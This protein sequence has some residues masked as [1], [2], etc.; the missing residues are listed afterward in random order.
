MFQFTYTLLQD[1]EG[2]IDLAALPF[3]GDNAED[4]PDVFHGFEVISPIPEHV[5]DPH[6]APTL[7]FAQAGADVRTRYGERGRD[8]FRMQWLLGEEEQG[9][10]L[11]NGPVNTPTGAHLAPVQDEFLFNRRERHIQ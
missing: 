6:D 5:D 8:F 9:M 2:G 10:H 11:G 7:Q 4:F 3:L 1:A